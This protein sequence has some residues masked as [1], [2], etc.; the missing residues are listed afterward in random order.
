MF[1]IST[2]VFI[3][4]EQKI[5]EVVLLKYVFQFWHELEGFAESAPFSLIKACPLSH[6]VHRLHCD[7]GNEGRVYHS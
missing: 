2:D 5:S 6:D 4:T 1:I 3:R 7:L